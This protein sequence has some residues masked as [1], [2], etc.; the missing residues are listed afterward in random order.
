MLHHRPFSHSDIQAICAF[1]QDAQ[2]LFF[3][4]PK[5]VYPLTPGQ[6]THAIEQ[7]S[8]STVVIRDG[9]VAGFANFYRWTDGICCIGN[10]AV[11]PAARGQGVAKYLIQ[12]MIAL[13]GARHAATLVQISCFNHNTAGLL[14]YAKLGFEPFNIEERETPD[15]QRTAL[16]HM[17]YQLTIQAAAPGPSA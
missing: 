1:P 2:E 8:D 12:T 10:V 11:A 15:G 7:R 16:I 14:L 3:F 6:L 9:K 4:Y 13:A 5:A 17:R